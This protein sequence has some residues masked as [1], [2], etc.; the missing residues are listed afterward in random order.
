[1]LVALRTL[2]LGDRVVMPGEQVA[3]DFPSLRGE[4]RLGRIGWQAEGEAPRTIKPQEAIAKDG[5]LHPSIR[6]AFAHDRA[7][8]ESAQ[9]AA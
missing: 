7:S 3:A 2:N 1:M 5:T 8:A 4:I 9:A 6:A